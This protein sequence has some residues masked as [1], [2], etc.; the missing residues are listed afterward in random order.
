MTKTVHP[1]ITSA[2]DYIMPTAINNTNAS[3]AATF[4]RSLKEYGVVA[5]GDTGETQTGVINFNIRRLIA[6][7]TPSSPEYEP[8]LCVYNDIMAEL[9]KPGEVWKSR[10]LVHKAVKAVS[11]VHGWHAVKQQRYIQCN[12]YGDPTKTKSTKTRDFA[13]GALKQNCTLRIILVPLVNDSYH[14]DS[15]L[16][17]P[18]HE[19]KKSFRPNWDEPVKIAEGTCTEH[20]GLCQ[21][22]RQNK[23]SAASRGGAYVQQMPQNT[24]FSLCSTLETSG[25]LTSETIKNAMK[26]VWPKAKAITKH[27]IFN[28]RVKVMKLMKVYRGSNRE[29]EQFKSVVN[30]SDLLQG[31]DNEALD[32]DEAYELCQQLWLEVLDSAT[33]NKQDSILN[34]IEYLELIK[35]RAQGFTYKLAETDESGDTDHRKKLRGVIWMTATMR[36]NWELFGDYICLDMMKRG[37]N[38]LLWP[39]FAV[40]LYDETGGLCVACEGIV[41]GERIDM[42][43]FVADFIGESAPGRSKEDVMIVAGDGFFDQEMCNDTLGFTNAAYITDVWHLLDQGLCKLFGKSGYTLLKGNLDGMV[44][45]NSEAEFEGYLNDAKN[46]LRSQDKPN[47]NLMKTLVDFASRRQTYA[48]YCLA[49]LPGN[50]GRHGNAIS[51]S[52]HS[53]VI[54]Y[55]NNGQKGGNGYC[56]NLIVLIRDLLKRQ[57]NHV[58]KTN[59]KL[60][61]QLQKMKVEKANLQRQPPTQQT[62]DLLTAANVLCLDSYEMYKAASNRTSEYCVNTSYFDTETQQMCIAVQSTRHTGA[63][64]RLFATKNSRCGCSDRVAYQ[65]MCTHEILLHGG[66]DKSL[67]SPRHMAREVVAGSLEGWLPNQVSNPVTSID[68]IIGFESENIPSDGILEEYKI[69]GSADS[70][71]YVADSDYMNTLPAA[72]SNSNYQ[73]QPPSKVKPL[74]VKHIENVFSNAIGG[75]SRMSED[76]KFAISH[77]IL[78]LENKL[79]MGN[80]TTNTIMHT[81]N[82]A[83]VMVPCQKDLKKQ[84]LKRLQARGKVESAKRSKPAETYT[85]EA[86]IKKIIH[87]SFCNG[88]HRVTSCAKKVSYANNAKEYI[89]TRDDDISRHVLRT[90]LTRV[91]LCP[92]GPPQHVTIYHQVAPENQFSNFIIHRACVASNNMPPSTLE[93]R[94]FCVSFIGKMGIV[95][96]NEFSANVWVS[97]GAMNSLTMHM[98]VKAKYVYDE[99][100]GMMSGDNVGVQMQGV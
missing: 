86:N 58:A 42:Y 88:N 22:G 1:I 83:A 85:V 61:G 66:F 15:M 71:M 28:I 12:R 84:P 91:Q 34:F 36:R 23:I 96:D 74:A 5:I 31:I 43:K 56:E 75:Y 16:A 59:N 4:A 27:D 33:S 98:N 25:R 89:L 7:C 11:D 40:T 46:V 2:D 77:L 99:T 57:K 44:K 35:L 76:E 3:P 41:C 6:T 30:A 45:A 47:Q 97:G 8:E 60:H 94:T 92:N 39:Y 72:S 49:E 93:G 81:A 69:V 50:L 62:Q 87:C 68:D 90:N 63:P 51:E 24:L 95:D 32:D 26:N 54:S 10:D 82:G 67:F 55:M 79:S 18:E 64:P 29:Y 52:N 37:L 9:F 19:R 100:Y 48:N 65:S 78:Q 14:P 53:S 70:D 17:K 38:T 20:G 13:G 73:H 80:T 21:P